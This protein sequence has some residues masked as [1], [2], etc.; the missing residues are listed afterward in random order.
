MAVTSQN[1]YAIDP[2]RTLRTVPGTNVKLVLADG[3]V[4]IVLLYIATAFD[5]EVESID[6]AAGGTPDDWGFAHRVIAGTQTYSNHASGTAIDL[7]ALRHP[8]G[9]RG[10][11]S[12][13][14][15]HAIRNIL[16]AAEGVIRWGGDYS[17]SSVDEM[18]WEVIRPLSDVARV[19]AKVGPWTDNTTVVINPPKTTPPTLRNGSTGDWVS[20]LQDHMNRVYP[21]YAKLQVDGVFGARTHA[22]MCEFQRRAKLTPDGIVGPATWHALGF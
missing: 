15:L 21:A 5:R 7:N 10:T 6:T 2:P 19:A 8:R 18:H 3:P 1:G 13:G 12:T 17:G 20:K 11:F 4:G 22:V 9:R 16:V 14:Q